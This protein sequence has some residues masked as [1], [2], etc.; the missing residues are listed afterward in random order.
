VK[1][2]AQQQ[3]LDAS[4]NS[5]PVAVG[6]CRLSLNTTSFIVLAAAL[7]ALLYHLPLLAFAR[8]KLDL[9]T[10]TGVL[11]M[12]TLLVAVLLMIILP[13]TL[14]ALMSPRVLKP[15]CMLT[16]VGNAIAL[17]FIVTYHVVLDETMM[18]NALNT[19][20]AE[21]SE[22]LH[23]RLIVYVLAFGLLP[24]W[25]IT[26]VHIRRSPRMH[27]LVMAS[28]ASLV[29]L[30]WAYLSGSAWPWIDENSKRLGGMVLPSSYLVNAARHEIPKIFS[31]AEQ[32]QL[33]PATFAS[34]ERTVVVLVIGEAA[35]AKNFELYGYA[36]STNPLLSKAGVVV[37]QNTSACATYTT[38]ALRCILSS[39]DSQS[40]FTR[41]YEPLPSYLQRNGVEVIWRTANFG[42]PPIK[43]A[44]YQ[45]AGNLA[46][47]CRGLRCGYDEV[48]LLGLEQRI[49]ASSSERTLVIIHQ[50]GSHGPAYYKRYPPE[51]EHFKPVCNSV[52]LS[53]CSLE[54]LINTY[55]NTI[56]YEDYLLYQTIEVLKKLG[57]IGSVLLYI[58]DHG[59]SLGEYGLYLHGVPYSIAP[60][61]QKN[62][63]F[64]L[65]M[66]DEFIRQK[67][68]E[69]G[70]LKSQIVHSQRDIF[71]SIMGAFSMRSDAYLAN[72][73]VFSKAFDAP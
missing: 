64:I 63:P 15:F 29:T 8:G 30:S 54:G 19:D 42:E 40:I 37:L 70:R 43:V 41:Q 20:F 52:E 23:P 57:N 5:T 49:R 59:E 27:L 39:V 46:A 14:L 62:I 55:D 33:P 12:S 7:N 4:R 68:V 56:V 45:T 17:Y 34:S 58:S 25:G 2:Q 1:Q 13:L 3:P 66:S 38:A 9:I 28:V 67:G 61:E 48:L 26:R 22:L 18:G 53:K 69:A 32:L 6:R 65:W 60:G 10:G 21:A 73:D 72:Y 35:R 44:S 24:C 71:H 16:A 50:G 31:P 47:Q 11:T 51:F 36:R